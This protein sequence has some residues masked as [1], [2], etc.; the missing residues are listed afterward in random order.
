[1][2]IDGDHVDSIEIYLFFILKE[3]NLYEKTK[4]DDMHVPIILSFSS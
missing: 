4:K 2:Y 3:L 1:M